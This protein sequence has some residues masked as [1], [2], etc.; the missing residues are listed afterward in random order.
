L[1][2]AFSRFLLA[3]DRANLSIARHCLADDRRWG[4]DARK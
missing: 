4:R 2:G 1:L 3:V